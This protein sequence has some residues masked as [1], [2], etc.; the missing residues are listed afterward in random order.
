MLCRFVR[1]S[2]SALSRPFSSFVTTTSFPSV[3]ATAAVS[4]RCRV[5]S[6]FSSSSFSSSCSST[7]SSSRFQNDVHLLSSSFSSPFTCCSF[8]SFSSSSSSSFFQACPVNESQLAFGYPR[9]SLVSSSAFFFSHASNSLSPPPSSPR[10]P[11]S[12]LSPGSTARHSLLRTFATSSFTRDRPHLN[13]GTIGHVDH[14]KT[15]LTAAITKVLEV[16]G[17]TTFVDYKNIDK[18]PEEQKRGITIN[19]THV[20]YST[21]SRHYGHVDCPGHADYV[22]NMITGAAQMDGAVLVVSAHDGPM[23]QTREHV[24]LA[25]HIGVPRLVVFL[26]KMDMVDD[27]ELVELVELEVR[28]LLGANGFDAEATPVVKGSALKALE[29]DQG[30]FGRKA[31]EE[32]LKAC[33]EYILAPER[34]SDKPLLLPI[35]SVLSIPGKGTVVTGRLECGSIRAGVTLEL[36]GVKEKNQ[37]VQVQALEMFRKT[38]D[39]AMAGD[40]VGLLLKG[41]KRDDVKRGMVAAAVGSQKSSRKFGCDLYVMTED[42]GG[43]KKPFFSNYRPQ[44]FLRTGD[45]ACSIQLQEGTEMANPGDNVKCSVELH[46][47]MAVS[48]GLRFTLREGGKTVASG[49]ISNVS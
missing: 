47:P 9:F 48:P 12:L 25:K 19:A 23:P 29:G 8:S 38:L 27:L 42:E 17:S 43:R 4:S 32:L 36:V 41:V 21:A 49:L 2:F 24:M 46:H 34:S 37:K 15:T 40:Q 31:V 11:L 33:D 16:D 39:E 13:I 44:A 35:D 5:S 3:T 20:E 22:K 10:P 6:S 14:G 26:N 1:P 45:S 30:K 18:T 7:G 28:D